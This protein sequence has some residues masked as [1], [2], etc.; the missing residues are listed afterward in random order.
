[1]QLAQKWGL[2]LVGLGAAYLVFTNPE[3]FYKAATGI[4]RLTA[5]SIVNITTGGK[6]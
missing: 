5:G 1:M 3:G 2:A 4:Q 6:R